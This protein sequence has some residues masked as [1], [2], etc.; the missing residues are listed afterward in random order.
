MLRS[1]FISGFTGYLVFAL[2]YALLQLVRGMEPMLSWLGLALAAG[3]PAAFFAW[4]YIAGRARTS[5]HPLT[6]SVVCGLGT[7]I[8]MAANWRFG[9]ASGVVHLW[10]GVCL[11]AWFI[12]LRWYS[13]FG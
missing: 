4:L 3:A 9:A 10:A 1:I 13:K 8:T 12:Y 11:L 2:I 5:A 6:V 7:A